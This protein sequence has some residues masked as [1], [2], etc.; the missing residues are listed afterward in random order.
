[1]HKHN[2]GIEKSFCTICGRSHCDGYGNGSSIPD[3]TPDIDSIE[4]GDSE[5]CYCDIC[6]KMI[7]EIEITFFSMGIYDGERESIPGDFCYQC[8]KEKIIPL[9]KTQGESLL[10]NI[11]HLEQY[12]RE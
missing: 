7:P 5:S 6:G 3:H 9:M 11:N 1:M 8:V 10:K 4:E 12:E 2:R